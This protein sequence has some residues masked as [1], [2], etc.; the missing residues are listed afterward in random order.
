MELDLA[1]EQE[2]TRRTARQFAEG[3]VRPRAEEID[4]T[5]EFPLDLVE[6]AGALGLMGVIV[7]REHGGLG[8]DT[9]S[10]VLAV[11]EVSRTSATVGAILSVHNFLVCDP[12]LAAG[13]G[14]QKRRY[15]PPLAS[16]EHIGCY[17]LTEPE[18][19]SDVANQTATAVRRGADYVLNGSKIFITNGKAAQVA[20]VYASTDRQQRHQGITAFVVETERPGFRFAKK[21]RLLG[22]HGSACATLFLEDCVVPASNRLGAEGEGFKIA[23]ASLDGGRIG[24]AALAVGIAQGALDEALSYAKERTQFGQAL[25]RFQ[26]IQWKLADMATEIEAARLLTHRAAFARDHQ[27]R[28]SLEASTAKLFASEVSHR[29]T[30]G[31][32]Q[33]LG[34]HGYSQDHPVE[35]F[36]RDARMTEID[37]GTSEIQ[38]SVIA[39]NLLGL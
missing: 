10:L 4:R 7:P 35:R 30:H 36:Y 6:K 37:Q 19:G 16:G 32:V 29:V 24:M 13:D 9:L 22:I 34:G 17:C 8:M 18:A 27:P 38:R 23:L 21:E 39:R 20:L 31:A 12:I 28:C 5:D 11:E 15:L 25:S 2:R 1:D 14:D 3:E 26:A 33:V